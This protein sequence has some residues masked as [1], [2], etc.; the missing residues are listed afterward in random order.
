MRFEIRR[1]PDASRYTTLYVT[2]DQA[3]AMTTAD[4]IVVMNQGRIE[5]VGSPEEA[6][7]RPR[8]EFVARLLGG[9]NILRGRRL[10]DRPAPCRRRRPPPPRGQYRS[11]RKSDSRT[12]PPPH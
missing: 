1:L 8:S 11:A 4:L 7:R 9:T 12:P 10:C 2:H 5:Q 3:E 6:Y